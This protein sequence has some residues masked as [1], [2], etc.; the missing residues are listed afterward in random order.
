MASSTAVFGV[1]GAAKLRVGDLKA[2]GAQELLRSVVIKNT[3]LHVEEE[4]D[5]SCL[6][7][8]SP[9]KSAPLLQGIS[10]AGLSALLQTPDDSTARICSLP[11]IPED[12][13][14]LM[15]RN[16]P[17]SF[18]RDTLMAVL[19]RVGFKGK[20]DFLYLPIH[21]SSDAGFG[22]AFVNLVTP[23]VVPAFTACIHGFNDWGVDSDLVAEVAWSSKLQGLDHHIE[24]YRNSPVMH[25]D[26]PDK[27]KPIILRSGSR[28][29]FPKPTKRLAQPRLR[30][31]ARDQ[32]R[33]CEA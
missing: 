5:T 7:S 20:Y 3:F 24:R 2:V 13:T 4:E 9:S 18:T 12:A 8:L 1:L 22:Y 27:Y 17:R 19:D 23:S 31:R 25:P 14:T 28:V 26:M 32:F 29:P 33:W 30:R 6:P 15:I 10:Q 16:V 11:D 21:F